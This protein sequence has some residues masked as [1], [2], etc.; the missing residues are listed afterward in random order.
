MSPP[1]PGLGA[2]FDQGGASS[3]TL[4][5]GRPF[6]FEYESISLKLLILAD[7]PATLAIVPL[8][9]ALLPLWKSFHIGFYLSSYLSAA[10]LLISASCQ[11]LLIGHQIDQWL[12]CGATGFIRRFVDGSVF[13]LL[14]SSSVR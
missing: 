7:L 13:S 4:L 11:W 6:H 8:S 1:A 3:A 5:A 12:V 2:F 14:Q 9:L 10:V